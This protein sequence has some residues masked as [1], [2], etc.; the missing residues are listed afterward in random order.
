MHLFTFEYLKVWFFYFRRHIS[1]R[2]LVYLNSARRDESNGIYIEFRS[3]WA[4]TKVQ[5]Q[6]LLQFIVFWTFICL[7]FYL[8]IL[9]FI[10]FR[11]CDYVAVPP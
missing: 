9:S 7:N 8:F 11:L 3:W 6:C 4:Y 5:S 10:S 2:I 1:L